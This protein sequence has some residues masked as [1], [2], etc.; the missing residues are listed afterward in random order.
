MLPFLPCSLWGPHGPTGPTL[1]HA[2]AC[3][4]CS[5]ALST[6]HACIDH[7]HASSIL[8][9]LVAPLSVR[10]SQAT[11]ITIREIISGLRS[12]MGTQTSVFYSMQAAKAQAY[13]IIIAIIR[14]ASYFVVQTTSYMYHH[15]C[16]CM[17]MS[18]KSLVSWLVAVMS[19][20]DYKPNYYKYTETYI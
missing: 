12:L 7:P 16:N 8:M 2:T 15:V 1:Q 20:I 19:I 4:S 13:T 9:F 14:T 11:K 10:L 5:S 17:C 18:L 6:I 3:M